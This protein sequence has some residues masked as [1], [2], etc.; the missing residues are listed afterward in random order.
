MCFVL[1]VPFHVFTLM[2]NEGERGIRT[3]TAILKLNIVE[4]ELKKN[5]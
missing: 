3:L 2:I 4:I 1:S 5:V